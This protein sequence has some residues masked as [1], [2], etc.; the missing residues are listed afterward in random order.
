MIFFGVRPLRRA[1]GTL[2][3]PIAAEITMLQIRPKPVFRSS[4]SRFVTLLML[5]FVAD[6]FRGLMLTTSTVYDRFLSLAGG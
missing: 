4:R 2:A 5:P 1:G 3:N 6:V